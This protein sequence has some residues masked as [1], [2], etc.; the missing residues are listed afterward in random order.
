MKKVFLN[1]G[2]VLSK[3]EQMSINGGGSCTEP[4]GQCL[5]NDNGVPLLVGYMPCDCLCPPQ[6]AYGMN[7]PYQPFCFAP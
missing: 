1:I 4:K 7:D 5:V 6:P 3:K 2:E